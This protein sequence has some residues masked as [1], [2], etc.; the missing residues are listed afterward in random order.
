V[1]VPGAAAA[2]VQRLSATAERSGARLV[3]VDPVTESRETLRAAG[4]TDVHESLDAA[5]DVTA[6]VLREAAVGWPARPLA[7]SSG[8]ALLVASEDVAAPRN[9]RA[10]GS[11]GQP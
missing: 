10:D 9:E 1:Q 6:K 8:D 2:A 7:P 11:G 4:V 3:V 5:L